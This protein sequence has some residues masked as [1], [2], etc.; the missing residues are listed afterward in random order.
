MD[1]SSEM[2]NAIIVKINCILAR[3]LSGGRIGHLDHVPQLLF[4]VWGDKDVGSALTEPHLPTGVGQS[5]TPYTLT[6][7]RSVKT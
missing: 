7:T 5:T 2:K 1:G 6:T 4:T 3:I